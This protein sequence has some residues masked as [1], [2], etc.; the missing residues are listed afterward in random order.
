MLL[1]QLAVPRR[2]GWFT[3]DTLEDMIRINFWEVCCIV[4]YLS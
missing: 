1:S 3:I 4:V 2:Q